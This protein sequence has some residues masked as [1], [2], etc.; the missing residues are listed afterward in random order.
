MLFFILSH[1]LPDV[2][3]LFLNTA[4]TQWNTE[5]THNRFPIIAHVLT[6]P[7]ILLSM[8]KSENVSK[9]FHHVCTKVW[10]EKMSSG[11]EIPSKINLIIKPDHVII[12][13]SIALFFH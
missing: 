7:P 3:F 10:R 13:D 11:E 2:F 1:H 4:F 5:I 9:C 12:S 8:E 6:K